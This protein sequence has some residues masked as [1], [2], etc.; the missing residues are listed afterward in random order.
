MTGPEKSRTENPRVVVV[1]DL[2]FDLLAKADGPVA[3]GT[4]T[5]API[6]AVAGGSGANAAAWLA[7]SGVETHFVG[8][9]GDDAFGAFL[10]EE[11]ESAG[12]AAAYGPDPDL[13]T[14]KVFV[15]VDGAGERTMITDRGAGENLSP[16]DLPPDLFNGGHLHLSGYTF[17][18]DSRRETAEEALRLARGGPDDRLGRPLLRPAVGVGGTGALSRAHRRREPLLPEP[19]RGRAANRGVRPRPHR[20]SVARPLSRR[21]PQARGLRRAL[22]GYQR[23]ADARPGGPGSGR[24]HHGGRRRPVR[25]FPLRVALGRNRRTVRCRGV[26]RWPRGRCSWSA[27]GR[28]RAAGLADV[29]RRLAGL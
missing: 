18:G 29:R 4:D 8:R 27:P 11:L 9:T 13:P 16:N 12:V 14:G 3:L 10:V 1:G 21:R 26:S 15:L 28:R 25:G 24:G 6:R 19:R 23:R 7:A 17:L 20:R 2:I 5:F 22:R